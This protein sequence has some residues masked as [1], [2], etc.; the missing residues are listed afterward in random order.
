M[1]EYFSAN[2]GLGRGALF[3]QFYSDR[4]DGKTFD[5]K[6]RGLKRFI[7]TNYITVYMRR[8]KTEFT[9]LM[10]N[11]FLDDVI[12]KKSKEFEIIKDIK[13]D[14]SGVQI[15]L[16]K[17][18]IFKYAFYFSPL[19]TANRLKSNF[20]PEPIREIDFD[21]YV[22]LDNRYLTDEMINLLE[23]WNTC[24]RQRGIVKLCTFGNR[25]TSRNPFLNFFDIDL[26]IGEEYKT[27]LYKDGQLMIQV[28][29]NEY[30][31]QVQTQS[32]LMKLV[33]GTIYENYMKGGILTESKA[34]IKDYPVG[35]TLWS[36]FI[37]DLGE[38]TIWIYEDKLY[39]SDKTNKGE[40]MILSDKPRI[41]KDREVFTASINEVGNFLKS[42]YRNSC[43]FATNE[44]AWN[45]FEP[46]IK[47]I[48]LK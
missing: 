46:I 48:N 26:K 37:T 21:E 27:R 11:T 8:W 12:N 25:I 44:K 10:I 1:N 4:S 41:I 23:F 39:I 45:I 2:G 5:I 16:C 6:Y 43:M 32:P 15:K 13:S 22:P 18:N 24:D 19:S 7:K 31:R 20:N 34:I 28:Y 33:E 9:N 17:E 42:V 40:K 29:H 36:A 30:R 14:R 47:L 38:G 3:N 35:A